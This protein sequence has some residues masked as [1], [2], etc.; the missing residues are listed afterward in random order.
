[1]ARPSKLA[2]GKKLKP[3][4][5]KGDRR[6]PQDSSET[7]VPDSDK[8]L[9]PVQTRIHFKGGKRYRI[10]VPSESTH[11][12]YEVVYGKCVLKADKR[13]IRGSSE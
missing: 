12:E 10:F 6:R 5:I 4:R 7:D 1:M 2:S 11:L 13:K 8:K 9:M 3:V